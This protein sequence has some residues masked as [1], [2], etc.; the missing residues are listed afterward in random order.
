MSRK[1]IPVIVGGREQ[2]YTDSLQAR[3]A[4]AIYVDVIKA[5]KLLREATVMTL[6]RYK[7]GLVQWLILGTIGDGPDG[8][9]SVTAVANRVGV[10]LAQ[11]SGLSSKLVSAKLV[12]QRT[13][14]DDH[15]NRH[16]MLS[17][18]GRLLLE[19]TEQSIRDALLTTLKHIPKQQLAFYYRVNALLAQ[20][21][22]NVIK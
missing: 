14:R 20:Q 21:K 9:L 3:S 5:D 13:Q 15:R 19:N 22:S 18:R 17:A 8:G 10:S 1:E 16:L 4:H 12:R 11:A 2:P 7:L 6:K